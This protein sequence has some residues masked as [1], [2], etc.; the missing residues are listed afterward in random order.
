MT[1]TERRITV[2]LQDI[3]IP[4]HLGGYKALQKAIRLAYDDKTAYHG[5]IVKGLYPAVAEE[6]G[7]GYTASQIERNIRNAIEATFNRKLPA[8]FE[9]YINPLSGKV[10]NS[11]F[12]AWCVERL[13][14][15]DGDEQNR[16]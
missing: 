14:T 6:T 15:E 2:L 13:K 3:G 4:P 16:S 5:R 9:S 8:A 10:A 11:E 1:I 7:D 12:I